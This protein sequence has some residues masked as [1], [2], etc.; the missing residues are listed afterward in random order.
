MHIKYPKENLEFWGWAVARQ[1]FDVLVCMT[2]FLNAKRILEFG[3]WTSTYAFIMWGAN[4]IHSY[5]EDPDFADKWSKEF[6]KYPW[7]TIFKYPEYEDPEI[8]YDIAFVDG[9][10]GSDHLSRFDALKYAVKHAR[11]TILHD[12]KRDWENESLEELVKQW[13]EMYHMDTL[14]W[15][16]FISKKR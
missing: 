16:T 8:E 12:S 10:R 9:P 1:D 11:V 5:E 7:I 14:V 15:M 2:R 6:E 13:Y 4:Y 3:P